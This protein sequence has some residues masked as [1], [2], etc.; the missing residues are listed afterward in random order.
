MLGS[1]MQGNEQAE[2]IVFVCGYYI[3]HGGTWRHLFYLS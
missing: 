1:Y 2:L 3:G